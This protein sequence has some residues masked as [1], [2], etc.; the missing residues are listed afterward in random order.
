MDWIEYDGAI[1]HDR[2]ITIRSDPAKAA[3]NRRTYPDCGRRYAEKWGGMPGD[4]R[5]DSPYGLPV[6]L[7]YQKVDLAGRA[8]RVWE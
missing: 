3:S 5:F 2:S 4:E 1:T 8:A 6:P 7:S